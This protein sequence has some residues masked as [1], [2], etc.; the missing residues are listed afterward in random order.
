MVTD[1]KSFLKLVLGDKPKFLK[2]M[3]NQ[4]NGL[5]TNDYLQIMRYNN[6]KQGAPDL[7]RSVTGTKI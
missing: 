6:K 7:I 3:L 4:I 5:P 1:P 2:I